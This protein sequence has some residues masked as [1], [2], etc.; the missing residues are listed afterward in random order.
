MCDGPWQPSLSLKT[1]LPN[2]RDAP[3][4]LLAGEV[5]YRRLA[6]QD[7]TSIAAVV[8]DLADE[9]IDARLVTF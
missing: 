6:Y 9:K 5:E 3:R 7:E 8:N 2:D 4:H 1:G